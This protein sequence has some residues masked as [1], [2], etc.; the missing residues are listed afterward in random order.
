MQSQSDNKFDE[1][2]QSKNEEL[3]FDSSFDKQW[4]K[5]SISLDKRAFLRFSPFRSNIYYLSAILFALIGLAVLYFM[6]NESNVISVESAQEKSILLEKEKKDL[7]KDG[8]HR[9]S[10]IKNKKNPTITKLDSTS[11]ENNYLELQKKETLKDT[12]TLNYQGNPNSTIVKMKSDS[13]VK[14][15]VKKIR[16]I[17]KRDTIITVDTTKVR[18]KR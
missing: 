16:Y 7:N 14:P 4:D 11:Q 3:S 6:P 5:I 12:T 10:T 17:T 2:I 8:L 9:E 18:R 15:I 13:L 1:F